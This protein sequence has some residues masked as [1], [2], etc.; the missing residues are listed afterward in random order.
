MTVAELL[1]D[2]YVDK[3]CLYM[4]RADQCIDLYKGAESQLPSAFGRLEVSIWGTLRG[5]IVDIRV[6][7]LNDEELQDLLNALG[8]EESSLW[9]KKSTSSGNDQIVAA[10][11]WQSVNKSLKMLAKNIGVAYSGNDK[12]GSRFWVYRK[13]EGNKNY[14]H[15]KQP[16]SCLEDAV[17]AAQKYD[18]L[19]YIQ[20]TTPTGEKIRV[21]PVKEKK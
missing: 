14:T 11:K 16:Y 13:K 3:I 20:E 12:S 1:K 10:E 7:W 9:A 6:V 8:S 4:G 15:T 2:A 21:I 18:G 17:I 5:N 19:T